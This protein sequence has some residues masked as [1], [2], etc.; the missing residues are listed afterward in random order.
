MTS[1]S[2]TK[3][4]KTPD[5]P[6]YQHSTFR[7]GPGAV[8]EYVPDQLIAYRDAHYIQD[9]VVEMDPTASFVSM[10]IIT[11]GW[12]PDGTLFRYDRIQLRQEVRM[13]GRPVVVDNLLVRPGSETAP[14]E[15]LLS[16]EDKT[17]VG[18][19]LAMDARITQDLVDEL[20]DTT[21]Q[22]LENT[23]ALLGSTK[24]TAPHPAPLLGM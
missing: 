9:T 3:V 10:E 19:L 21:Q 7:L 24:L 8:L 2:A 15:S 16:M 4:Y 18:S 5:A 23:S 1:Q 22:V 11:P 17:H 13:H 20:R 6:A 14:A 12:A